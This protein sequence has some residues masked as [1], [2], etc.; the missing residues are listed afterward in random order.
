MDDGVLWDKDIQG[1]FFRTCQYLTR[2]SEAGILFTEDKF[3][4]CCWEIDFLGFRV[5]EEGVKPSKDFLKAIED[6]PTPTNITG[7]RSWFGLIEQSSYAFSKT[8]TI[9]KAKRQVHLVT[10]IE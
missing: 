4:F 8:K 7:I 6:F 2:C 5:D 3:Q 9:V 1:N 10:R